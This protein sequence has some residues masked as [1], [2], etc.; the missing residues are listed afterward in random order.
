[1]LHRQSCEFLFRREHNWQT[2][3][4]PFQCHF[5]S[6]KG[7]DQN[8]W[9]RRR[10]TGIYFLTIA[11]GLQPHMSI[12]SFVVLIFLYKTNNDKF[13]FAV[14]HWN[15]LNTDLTTFECHAVKLLCCHQITQYAC[16]CRFNVHLTL[17]DAKGRIS[18]SLYYMAI[19]EFMLKKKNLHFT[20]YIILSAKL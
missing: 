2:V 9:I 17:R 12:R 3:T 4:V 16:S 1:M 20:Q 10:V 18:P 7:N 5:S 13:E 19:K 15:L 6:V 8:H 11:Y 14:T